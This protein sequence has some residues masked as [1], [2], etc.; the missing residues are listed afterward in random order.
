M[1][2]NQSGLPEQTAFLLSGYLVAGIPVTGTVYDRDG[3]IMGRSALH[4]L[5][6]RGLSARYKAAHLELV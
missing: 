6:V 1:D 3:I 2:Y 4:R 5:F